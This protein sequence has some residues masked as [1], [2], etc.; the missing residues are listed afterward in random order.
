VAL[1]RARLFGQLGLAA[2]WCTFGVIG[3]MPLAVS[4]G[5]AHPSLTRELSHF[6]GG[7]NAISFLALNGVTLLGIAIGVIALVVVYRELARA[8]IQSVVHVSPAG[9]RV[10]TQGRTLGVGADASSP[11]ALRGARTSRGS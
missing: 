8:E 7:V 4:L 11:S 2:A 3:L 10:D 5:F 9:L 1:P 6:E